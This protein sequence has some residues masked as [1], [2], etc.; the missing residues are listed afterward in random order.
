[1]FT[2]SSYTL[3]QYEVI[4]LKDEKGNGFDVVPEKGASLHQLFF[5]GNQVLDAFT[6]AEDLDKNRW[7][8]QSLLFPFPNRLADGQYSW[9]G[10][11]YQFPIN[12]VHRNNNLHGFMIHE[13]FQVKGTRVSEEIAELTLAYDYYGSFDYYPFPCSLEVTYSF[14]KESF[15]FSF[16]IKNQSD[17]RMPFG[18]GWHPYFVF[19]GRTAM[20][21][22]EVT[23]LLT[24]HRAIPTGEEESY[25]NYSAFTEVNE[26]L[27][28]GLRLKSPG[29]WSVLLGPS[30]GPT[31]KLSADASTPYIQVFNPR[32]NCIAVEPQTCAANAFQNGEGLVSLGPWEEKVCRCELNYSS[33]GF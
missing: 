3:G 17:K 25:D 32:E 20:Q 13:P 10:K 14:L 15:Q 8:K 33:S 4:S 31:L 11:T 12:E 28:T 9:E 2:Q 26:Q 27:D 23:H 7:S 22:P 24:D 18:F 30:S 1:M 6:D 5:R 29:T 19:P 16:R 21:L